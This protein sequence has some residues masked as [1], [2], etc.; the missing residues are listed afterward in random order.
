MFMLAVLAVVL[1]AAT[2]LPQ[3]EV[4][5][6]ACTSKGVVA[7]FDTLDPP[8]PGNPLNPILDTY[9]P[10]LS[11]KAIT[12]GSIPEVALPA[13]NSLVP[14]LKPNTPSNVAN[15]GIVGKLSQGNPRISASNAGDSFT[16]KDFTYGCRIA[17]LPVPCNFFLIGY[18][19]LGTQKGAF[20]FSYEP[21][22]TAGPQAMKSTK[23]NDNFDEYFTDVA[24]IQLTDVT[25]K[26]SVTSSTTVVVLDTLELTLN[27]CT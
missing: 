14:Y 19:L 9:I 3:P 11:F 10:G 26:D 24:Y 12:Y 5:R 1:R 23:G 7:N 6:R 4:F 15:A 17:N 13:G 8:V 25:D 18:T 22:G 2:A 21:P 27:M 16:L 20:K